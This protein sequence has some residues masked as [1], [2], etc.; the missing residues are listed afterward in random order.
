[1]QIKYIICQHNSANG[2][3]HLGNFSR[4]KL[5]GILNFTGNMQLSI[6]SNIRSNG[7]IFSGQKTTIR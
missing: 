6:K 4:L 5:E 7:I 2:K 1:M 3:G